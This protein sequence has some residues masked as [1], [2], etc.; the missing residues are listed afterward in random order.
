[1]LW[2]WI[3]L[4]ALSAADIYLTARILERG[5]REAGAFG[6]LGWLFERV[7]ALPAM[8]GLKVAYLTLM[9][10]L[11]PIPAAAPLFVLLAAYWGWVVYRNW[12]QL[13]G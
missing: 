5:G 11:I 6:F 12:G 7:G 8:V 4:V 2:L 1:M 13:R 9:W 10:A 3:L